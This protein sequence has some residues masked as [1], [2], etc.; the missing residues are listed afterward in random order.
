MLNFPTY[1]DITLSENR[2]QNTYVTF[3]Y[4]ICR[5]YERAGR[6][7]VQ[8]TSSLR[9][10]LNG[11]SLKTWPGRW[12]PRELA[13]FE[14]VFSAF[15]PLHLLKCSVHMRL[16]CGWCPPGEH[17]AHLLSYLWYPSYTC[18]MKTARKA[19][20]FISNDDVVYV[21]KESVFYHSWASLVIL[22]GDLTHSRHSL[23][24]EWPFRSV[25]SFFSSWSLQRT[26][27]DLPSSLLLPLSAV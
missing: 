3:M 6:W 24:V 15:S 22:T 8:I 13:Y 26:I 25:A 1:S 5:R 21:E 2:F 7:L 12:R 16:L 14:P 17:T 18:S 19:P 23:N 9:L 11:L 4:S 10:C 20:P 27:P